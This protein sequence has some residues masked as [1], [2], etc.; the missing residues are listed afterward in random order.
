MSK[1]KILAT[2]AMLITSTALCKANTCPSQSILTDQ[3]I[4]DLSHTG[5]TTIS[6]KVYKVVGEDKTHNNYKGKLLD[7]KQHL[8][9]FL[10][11]NKHGGDVKARF[12]SVQTPE[13]YCAYNISVGT[14]SAMV[15][16]SANPDQTPPR[17]S[18]PSPSKPPRPTTK[19]PDKL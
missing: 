5:E 9:G 11:I 2:L 15:A 17:P 6:G 1:G 3:N 13:G 8:E 19:A 4:T 7:T 18:T 14:Q 10:K 16:L 12:V